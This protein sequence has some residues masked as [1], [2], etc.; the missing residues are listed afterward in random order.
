MEQLDLAIRDKDAGERLFEE[1]YAMPRLERAFRKV[2]AN[3]GVAGVDEGINRNPF[4]E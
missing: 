4:S 2:K 1:V 3:K